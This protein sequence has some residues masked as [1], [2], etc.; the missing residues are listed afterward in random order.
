MTASQTTV[1]ALYALI[2]DRAPDAAG[3]AYWTSRLDQGALPQEVAQSLLASGEAAGHASLPDADFVRWLYQHGLHRDADADGLAWWIDVLQETTRG[4]LLA[5]WL[6]ALLEP[7]DGGVSQGDG[8][9]LANKAAAGIEFAATRGDATQDSGPLSQWVLR[10]LTDDPATLDLARGLTQAGP[11]LLV[12]SAYGLLGRVPDPEGLAFWTGQWQAGLSFDDMLAQVAASDE[13]RAL[14]PE[15]LDDTDFVRHLYA[16]AVGR[17]ADEDGLAYWTQRLADGPGGREQVMAEFFGILAQGADADGMLYLNR[18]VLA[19]YFTQSPY[20]DDAQFARAV[21]ALVTADRASLVEAMAWI[22]NG[23]GQEPPPQEPPP[24]V[25]VA[26]ALSLVADTGTAADDGLTRDGTVALTFPAGVRA[27]SYS[28]DGGATWQAGEVASFVLPEG[29]YEAGAIRARY[30]SSDGLASGVGRLLSAVTVD[31]TPPGEPSFGLAED[32]GA[33]DSDGISGDGTVEVTGIEDGAAWEYSTDGGITWTAGSGSGFTLPEGAHAGGDVQ[34]RQTDAAGNVSAVGSNAGAFVIDATAPGVPPAPILDPASDSGAAGDDLTN[35]AA[36]VITG[37]AE[38]GSTVRL[39]DGD[40]EIGVAV[41]DA[42]TGA[43]S[44]AVSDALADG[45]HTLTVRAVDA[46][47]NVSEPSAALVLSIDTAVPAAPVLALAEDTGADDGDG[48]T[49]VGIIT[50]SGVEAG[51]TWDYSLDG[52]N[53]WIAGSGA[54]FTLPEGVHAGGDVQVRQVDAAGNTSAAGSNAGAFIIDTAAPAAPAVAMLDP[55]SDSGVAGDNLTNVATPV[56]TGTAEAGSTVRLYDGE[57]EIGVAVADALTGAWSLAV[58]DALADGE[59][60]L[61]V[62]AVDTAGNVSEPSAALVLTIDTDIPAAPVL[63]LAEDTGADDGDGITNV[64]TVVVSGVEAGATWEYSADGGAAWAVGSDGGF[65]L[66]EGVYA[67]GGIQ[68]RQTDI[69]GNVSAVGS[70][71]GAYVI[72]MTA[73]TV[74]AAPILDPASDS[75]AAGDGLTN[76]AA[77]VITGTAEAGST[78]RLYDSDTA[79]GATVADASTGAWSIAVGDVLVDGSH[80]LTV[81]AVDAAGNVSEVSTALILTIDT[82]IPDAPVLALAEDTGGDDGDGITNKGEISVSGLEPG[83]AWEYSID[84]GTT[85]IVGSGSG[86]TLPE[87]AYASGGIQVRQIDAAGNVGTVGS[88]AGALVIDATAPAVPAAPILDPAGDS[89]AA[90]DNLTNVAT[91]VITGLA[92][93]GS[94]VRLYD[95]DTEIGATVADALTGAWSITVGDALADGSHT[96]TVRAV[97]TAG[98]VSDPSAALVLTVDTDVPAAP[99]FALNSDTGADA[100]DGITS[101][102]ALSVSGLEPGA[103][104]EYSLDGGATWSMGSSGSFT[105]PEGVYASGDVQVRQIDAAGNTSAVGGNAGVFVIDATAPAAPLLT[106]AEDTGADGSDGITNDGA[107]IVSGLE[108]GATWEYS[109]DGGATWAAGSDGGF[110]LPEGI[111]ASGSIRVRQTDAAGNTSSDFAHAAAIIV[112]ATAPGMPSIISANL[113]HEEAPVIEGTAEAGAIV[114]LT[115]PGATYVAAVDTDGHW[116]VDLSTATPVSGTLALDLNSPNTVQA[117]ATDAAGN[118]SVFALQTL[119][120]DTTPP[121]PPAFA[122]AEDTGAD[123]GDG[124]TNVGIVTVSGVEAGATWEYSL[125]SGATWSL[126]GGGD[127]TLPEGT[128]ASG[129]VQVRQTDAAGNVSP[130]ALSEA[131]IVV[132]TTAPAAPPLLML[133]DSDPPAYIDGDGNTRIHTVLV[134]DLEDGATWQY[135]VDGGDTWASGSGQRFELADGAYAASTIQARQTDLA[136]NLGAVSAIGRSL[137]VDTVAPAAAAFAL[138]Q[139]TGVSGSDGRTLD[140]TIAVTGLEPGAAWEYSLNGG[141]T[142]HAGSGESFLLAEGS[143]AVGSISVRQ[144]DLAGNQSPVVHNDLAI[145]VD[146]TAPVAPAVTLVED[147]G[148]SSSDGITRDGRMAVG[149]LE[150]DAAWRFSIDGGTSWSEGVGAGFELAEGTYSAGSVQVR[151][152][153][154]AGNVGSLWSNA[155]TI[156]V[157]TAAAAL[158][159]SVSDTGVPGDG[160]TVDG[161]FR[162]GLLEEGA[163]WE[164][165]TDAGNT[166]TAG[167]GDA[168]ILEYGG[169]WD[170]A[171]IQVRQ[172]DAAGNVGAAASAGTGTLTILDAVTGLWQDTGRSATDGITANGV[173]S[174]P[175]EVLAADSWRIS[176]QGWD[177]SYWGPVQTGD[178]GVALVEGRYDPGQILIQYWAG[179]QEFLAGNDMAYVVDLTGPRVQSVDADFSSLTFVVHFDEQVALVPGSGIAASSWG[180]KLYNEAGVDLGTGFTYSSTIDADGASLGFPGYLVQTPQAGYTVDLVINRHTVLGQIVDLA[181]NDL[182]HHEPFAT[183]EYTGT[184]FVLI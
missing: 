161:T 4:E 183:W 176:T 155:A 53:T 166:W 137:V 104:W 38:A 71:A 139:D 119:V 140:G 33:S 160:V 152:I 48:I 87:G 129:S 109:L 15:G 178:V 40:T 94:T 148:I 85:W 110:A 99:V 125:D 41:A 91:P 93:A 49:N 153:D 171:D 70:N 141:D 147:T 84:S 108:P 54:S 88:S 132:D 7:W 16:A 150:S 46:A 32:T 57:T 138:A 173:L 76:A 86:F 5:Q 184:D 164:Y 101:D 117:V 135:S 81:R 146:T 89:G 122:L 83:A 64:G 80:T 180:L 31:T 14:Y 3:L 22:D 157:D 112:D 51:A 2:L 92:E 97:D 115:V 73:P 52:G 20:A 23:P 111:H 26:P 107:V 144:T 149:L 59:H 179:G 158:T 18:S 134:A 145:V 95:S 116:R 127:F 98:N 121:G 177:E 28:V 165:T 133:Y 74:P 10:V 126:G 24:S 29:E 75:G 56:I 30:V 1:A 8:A 61:I 78:V 42:L 58:S 34:V 6:Q 39:Y 131:A 175:E 82:E 118:G 66:P 174:L 100:G 90:G 113:T 36:P 44:L 69:A 102:G 142:W 79:I 37:T 25:P 105:L 168:F 11:A 130:A 124:I 136:G 128:Y 103:T 17:E 114:T 162:I 65:S 163:S 13:A 47:G 154:A 60:T 96:L 35:V 169:V 63:A 43:W 106:L 27:W 21:L 62:R 19:S 67:I 159:L 72:D 181:G 182:Q 9:L 167:T 77:P 151:Q 55:A 156:V 12:S 143:Y 45:A 50:V 170:L 68:V 123:D 172:T 120:I